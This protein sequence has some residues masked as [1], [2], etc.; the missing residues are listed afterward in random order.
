MFTNTT[1]QI[2]KD[3]SLLCG[4][5]KMYFCIQKS[6]FSSRLRALRGESLGAR[7]SFF[8]QECIQVLGLIHTLMGR[9]LAT[10]NTQLFTHQVQ[11]RVTATVYNRLSGFVGTSDCHSISE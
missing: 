4:I 1:D 2:R 5:S 11:T 8:P 7:L 10:D 3:R 9:K 6:S